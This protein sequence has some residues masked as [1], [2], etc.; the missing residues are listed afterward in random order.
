[1]PYGLIEFKADYVAG[2]CFYDAVVAL[3]YEL[4]WTQDQ[5]RAAV[6]NELEDNEKIYSPFMHKDSD[7]RIRIEIGYN[8]ATKNSIFEKVSRTYRE[9]CE[10]MKQSRVYVDEPEIRAFT[11]A[12]K[13][14]CV[15]IDKLNGTTI[16]IGSEFIK[17][18]NPPIFLCRENNDHYFP[19]MCQKEKTWQDV[20]SEVVK[21]SSNKPGM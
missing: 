18:D 3:R 16:P 7:G 17:S 1:M 10:H 9:Y 19:L 5:L 14:A 15:I 6:S 12:K 8:P 11:N 21:E 4:K 20:M 13:V 2:N